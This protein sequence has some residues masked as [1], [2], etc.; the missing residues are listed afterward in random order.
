MD[1]VT[2]CSPVAQAGK[3]YASH[4]AMPVRPM[5]PIAVLRT[6][7]LRRDCSLAM[8]VMRS[9]KLTTRAAT[10]RRSYSYGRAPLRQRRLNRF[11]S[12]PAS[13][14]DDFD[15]VCARRCV[16]KKANATD[17][18]PAYSIGRT[19]VACRIVRLADAHPYSKL[20]RRL[21]HRP[22]SQGGR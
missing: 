3:S 7:R 12:Q 11:K 1:P 16:S 9:V 20:A 14:K 4:R 6:S 17:A 5:S 19:R 10:G 8:R 22:A 15:L 2:N 18:I 13:T 21:Q